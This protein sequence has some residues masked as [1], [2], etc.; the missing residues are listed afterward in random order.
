[1]WPIRLRRS[2]AWFVVAVGLGV[3]VIPANAVAQSGNSLKAAAGSVPLKRLSRVYLMVHALNWLEITP[4]D[5]RRKTELWEQWPGRC[6]ICHRYEFALKEKY[7]R[8]M[9]TADESAGVFCLLSGLSGDLPL[10]EL[11]KKTFGDRCVVCRF[12]YDRTGNRKALGEEFARGL[13]RDR[14]RAE[15]V[16]GRNLT[17][18]E[19]AAWERSKAW[20]VDLQ[21]QL[22]ARGYTFDPARVEFITFGEDWCGCAATYPIHMGRALGLGRPMARRF[23][24]INPDCSPLLLASTAI[25]QNIPMAEHIRLFIFKTANGRLVAQCWEGMHG[26]MDKPHLVMVDFPPGSVRLTD[27]F[28]KPRDGRTYGRVPIHVGC[29][30]H[31]PYGADLVQAESSLPLKAFRDALLAGRVAEQ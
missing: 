13:E 16:R 18:G 22:E 25:E 20:C 10:I 29:G 30:G 6:E 7:Y 31:T 27:V 2:L 21:T 4:D 12:G 1:M 15:L 5:P 17:E 23:D 24:L 19:I 26:L 8:L 3:P 11:A 28:G 14:R 9:A